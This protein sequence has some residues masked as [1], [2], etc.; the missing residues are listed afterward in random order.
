[1]R[2]FTSVHLVAAGILSLASLT[3]AIPAC[4]I[5]CFSKVLTEHPPLTC[6]LPS[7][8]DCFCDITELQGYYIQCTKSDC[9]S[10]TDADD[11]IQF[12]VELCAELGYTITVPQPEATST[13]TTE[14]PDPTTTGDAQTTG[15]AET[16]ETSASTETEG[17]ETSGSTETSSPTE[18][19]GPETSSATQTE[20]S[21]ETSTA[22]KTSIVEE[23]SSLTDANGPKDTTTTPTKSAEV[24][25]KEQMTTSTIYDTRTYTIT[26][27]AATVTNCPVGHVTTETIAVT[28]TICPVTEK[29]TISTIYS[30]KTN[31]V[32]AC[33]PEVTDCLIGEVTI[34]TV[35]VSTTICPVSE[36]SHSEPVTEYTKPVHS[37]PVE[38]SAPWVCPDGCNGT[39][40][41]VP[42]ITVITN[43]TTPVGG[44]P[45]EPTGSTPNEDVPE[46]VVGMGAS[47]SISSFLAAAGVAIAIF[48]LL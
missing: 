26:A 36:V 2:S 41:G 15:D 44:A 32:T 21:E 14:L 12:G 20:T 16:T 45:S 13:T 27:C 25:N 18:T 7:M 48:G 5:D 11:A 17:T 31:M 42:S 8:Y 40:T 46:V 35:A 23:T 37:K 4:A 30:T 38:T 22:E 47:V 6:T 39:A 19:G 43:P 29:L 24:T 1:M 10:S 34:E 9:P 28:T 3:T 33:P